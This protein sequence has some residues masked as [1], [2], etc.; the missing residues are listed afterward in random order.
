MFARLIPLL[1]SYHPT[2]SHLFQV[3]I[4]KKRSDVGHF[5]YAKV[6]RFSQ[7]MN[8]THQAAIYR[9]PVPR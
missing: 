5:S 7:S 9:E 6:A 8:G 2:S 1:L 4:I 3:I